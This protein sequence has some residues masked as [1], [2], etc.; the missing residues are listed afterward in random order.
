[1]NANNNEKVVDRYH[2]FLKDKLGEGSFGVVYKGKDT[3]SKQTVAI[4]MLLKKQINADPYLRRGLM[5]EIK[6]MKKLKGANV[7]QLLDVLETT[8]N[9]YIVQEYCDSGDLAG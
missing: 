5:S 7:V 3:L 9:Y 1:M 4:K 6:I 8:N 2:F